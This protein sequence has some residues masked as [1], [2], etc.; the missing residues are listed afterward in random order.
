MPTKSSP[1]ELL[2][3]AKAVEQAVFTCLLNAHNAYTEQEQKSW[4]AQADKL[5][6]KFKTDTGKHYTE[7]TRPELKV[8]F[9]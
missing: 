7:F 3:L 2:V 5:E 9:T 4:F 8:F 6:S 1:D